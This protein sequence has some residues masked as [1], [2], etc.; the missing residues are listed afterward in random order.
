M[1]LLALLIV[2]LAR[3]SSTATEVNK[4]DRICPELPSDFRFG[5]QRGEEE[6]IVV[7]TRWEARLERVRTVRQLSDQRVVAELF[8]ELHDAKLLQ[9]TAPQCNL[10]TVSA[11]V[12]FDGHTISLPV[13]DPVV[14]RL[15]ERARERWVLPLIP[16]RDASN[17]R[18]PP[19]IVRRQ[20]I[21][22][23]AN[24][25]TRL[26]TLNLTSS[27]SNRI[28]HSTTV[29]SAA[30]SR[31]ELVDTFACA[32]MTYDFERLPIDERGRLAFCSDER[33]G[34]AAPSE[35]PPPSEMDITLSGRRYEI[36]IDFCTHANPSDALTQFAVD[37]RPFITEPEPRYAEYLRTG[38]WPRQVGMHTSLEPTF[39]PET[40]Y[41]LDPSKLPRADR[42][43]CG[44]SDHLPQ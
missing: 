20:T 24:A 8:C 40:P 34:P 5:T 44:S 21:S 41:R 17:Q 10:E 19:L 23:C 12:T 13:C 30:E 7:P 26:G 35:T 22:R 14:D 28:A 9:V 36:V 29:A 31:R 39:L 43:L 18:R 6:L 37:V 1:R 3:C 16:R 42:R 27:I 4:R 38:Y 33:Y 15:V 2:F 32:L 25:P 11:Q